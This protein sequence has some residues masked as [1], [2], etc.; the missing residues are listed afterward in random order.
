MCEFIPKELLLEGQKQ[1]I[2]RDATALQTDEK[3]LLENQR[4]NFTRDETGSQTRKPMIQFPI[5]RSTIHP[6]SHY[7]K[8]LAQRES[9]QQTP[10]LALDLQSE[11][12]ALPN[13]TGRIS[14]TPKRRLP[15]SF[16]VPRLPSNR[17]WRSAPRCS[18]AASASPVIP[19]PRIEGKVDP[20]IGDLR[21]SPIP[22]SELGQLNL[23]AIEI[24]PPIGTGDPELGTLR[25][26]E[27]TTPEP[28]IVLPT[29]PRQ[30][31][32]FLAVRAD[33]FK[34]SNVFSE[35]NSQ[36][37]ALFRTGLSFFYAPPIGSRTFLISSID[38][39]LIRYARLGQ[40]HN[41]DGIFF[42]SINYD[43][44]RLRIGVFHRITPRLAGEI[45]W[46]NQNLF[47]SGEGLR[48]ILSGE[49]FFGDNSLR[50]ELSR[51]DQLAPRVSLNTFYQF[52]WSFADPGDRSRILNSF[53][54]TLGYNFSSRLQ[55]ALDYQFSWSHFTQQSRDDLY[56]QLVARLTYNLSLRTQVNVFSGFSFGNSSDRRI[57]FNSFI[58]GVGL[59]FNL[60]LF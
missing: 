31:S 41:S 59:V 7:A 26:Q 49:R 55:T 54:A 8:D 24:D 48:H 46:S 19:I 27:R 1:K 12:I 21:L 30:P 40:D 13:L 36:D 47:T 56:H 33:Y 53:I 4:Q 51:Q 50:L 5:A 58:F 60:P 39:N 9:F 11:K 6:V 57:D 52:R 28:P 20:E 45:G 10:K 29:R 32:A 34:T 15:K 17:C 44:L 25:L 42:R 2:E 23:Q 37:D 35:V 16:P 14:T 22:E 18:F 38:A 3:R 43:E